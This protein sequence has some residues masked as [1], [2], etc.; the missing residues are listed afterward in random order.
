MSVYR[1]KQI[2]PEAITIR[3]EGAC[4][5]KR[6][7]DLYSFQ[8]PEDTARRAGYEN[9]GFWCSLCGWSNAGRRAVVDV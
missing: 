7:G 9:C 1:L 3:R 5:C 4:H 6:K 2:W 8:L